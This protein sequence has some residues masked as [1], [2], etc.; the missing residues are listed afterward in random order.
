MDPRFTGG[1]AAPGRPTLSGQAPPSAVRAPQP[2]Q[3]SVPSA[4]IGRPAGAVARPPTPAPGAPARLPAAPVPS[5]APKVAQAAAGTGWQSAVSGAAPGILT[6]EQAARAAAAQAAPAEA[7]KAAALQ[8]AD[9]LVAASQ[10]APAPVAPAAAP[11]AAPSAAPQNPADIPAGSSWSKTVTNGGIGDA[12]LDAALKGA[13]M[14][15]LSN[16][17]F[18]AEKLAAAQGQAFDQGAAGLA[19]QREGIEG[20]AVRRGL[21]RTGAA[22]ALGSEAES[23]MRASV[24]DTQRTN[25]TEFAKLS[26]EH[27]Q[28]AIGA[29]QNLATDLA[30]R[31]ISMEQLK[32]QREGAARGGGRGYDPNAPIEMVD[33]EGNVTSIDPRM[34]DL[35]LALG[36]G[37]YE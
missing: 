34:I 9:R 32:M 14:E 26:D 29:A 22:A 5:W 28:Q 19:A 16:D 7:A 13:V 20:D 23:A 31:G 36:E 21:S 2:Q 33:D 24:A 30:N 37:G 1:M 11:A 15:G 10:P 8:S 35:V 12:E 3:P 27:K 17:P 4:P 18:S 25:M 6:G